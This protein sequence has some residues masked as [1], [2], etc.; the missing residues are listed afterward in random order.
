M[1]S[2]TN[3]NT[4]EDRIRGILD[5]TFEVFSEYSFDDATTGEIARRARISKRDLYA[6]FP[7]KQA[8]LMGTIVREMQ[9]QNEDFRESVARTAELRSLRAKLELIGVAVVEGILSP[10]MGMVRRLVI[11]ESIKQPYLGNLYFENGVAQRCHLIGEVLAGHQKA[12]A[13][14]KRAE[15]DR[16]AEHFFS[17]IA[18]FP[19]TMTEIGMRGKWNEEAISKHVA[20]QAELFLKAHPA[21]E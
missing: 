7:N 11:S 10:R 15:A 20:A 16:A 13:A 17:T 2:N 6:C 21:F 12:N 3:G 9:R 8:L 18:F 4:K 1:T 14:R 19:S 5:A